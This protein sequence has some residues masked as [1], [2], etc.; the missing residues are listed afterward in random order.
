MGPAWI[1]WAHWLSAVYMTG[2]I[3]FVQCVH[4]PL[5]SMASADH[6]QA[7]QRDHMVRTT[8]VMVTW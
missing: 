5:M 1:V 3:W 2:L 7:F 4:Y 6:Y 8:W